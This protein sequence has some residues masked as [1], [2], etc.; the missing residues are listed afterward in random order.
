MSKGMTT[1]NTIEGAEDRSERGEL[2]GEYHK[3]YAGT[4]I[5]NTDARRMDGVT[6]G[7]PV[8]NMR[9]DD[10]IADVRNPKGRA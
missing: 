6:T 9:P 5:G 7:R 8:P 10:M 1:P 3:A 2:T 4:A